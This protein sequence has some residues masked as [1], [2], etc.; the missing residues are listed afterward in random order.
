MTKITI[1]A[2]PEP[3]YR[4][5]KGESL[6]ELPNSYTVIDIET[7]GFEI[8]FDEIIEVAA[9]R[10][11]DGKEVA[12]FQS[13][14]KPQEDVSEF[15]EE[16]TGITNE[17]L[18][19]APDLNSIL[20]QYRAFLGQDT[21]LGHN[22]HFD[23]NFI[24]DET[25]NLDLPALS[26]NFVDTLR[27]SRR[28]FP[29]LPNHKLETLCNRCDVSNESSHR[30]M[31]DCERTHRCYT[32]IAEYVKKKGIDLC[33]SYN[34]RSKTLHAETDHFNPDSPLYGKTFVFTGKLEFYTRKE[35]MQQ[36]LNAGGFC[37]D[38]VTMGTNYLVLG[39]NDYC[40][41]IKDG[42]SSKQKKAEKLQLQ[43]Y[44]IVTISESVFCDMLLESK[45][46]NGK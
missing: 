34:V 44:D 36:V 37:G 24:Y 2:A 32:Y 40:R 26:N 41:A 5:E 13:L 33:P 20:P 35:A 19:D 17:M 28:A 1:G 10:V 22:I 11:V 38:S 9:I 6:L 21:L 45:A 4:P 43:G 18:A 16:L 14:V 31:S 27:L 46:N 3:S 25:Y 8:S 12:H 30:A 15:I 29:E 42:K 39:N 7:T 23:I